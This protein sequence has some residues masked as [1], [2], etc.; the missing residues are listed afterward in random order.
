MYN[1]E[2]Y[3]NF[4]ELSELLNHAA[5]EYSDFCDLESLG[6]SREGRDVWL[7]TLTNKSSGLHSDKPA[8]W[9]SGNIHARELSGCQAALHTIFKILQGV[10]D[11]DP[12]YVHLLSHNTFY[13]VPRISPDGADAALKGASI[14][15]V[16]HVYPDADSPGF[17]PQDMDGDGV[18]RWILKPDEGGVWKKSE[19]DSRILVQRQPN[20][21]NDNITYYN[22]LPEGRFFG[23]KQNLMCV[24]NPW[25]L[26]YNRNFPHHWQ[27]E[28]SQM[29]AGEIPLS[30][31]ETRAVAE[32]I[33]SR[34]N[35]IGAQDFHTFS[36]VILRPGINIADEDMPVNDL[37]AYKA[38]A[39]IGEDI[40]GYPCVS[41]HEGFKIHKK[42]LLCGGFIDWLYSQRGA[43]TFST[44]IWNAFK[45]SGIE[46]KDN[47]HLNFFISYI[48]AE[49]QSK[50][51]EWCDKNASPGYFKNWEKMNHMDL[52][53]IEIGGMD[54]L[55]TIWNPP[56]KLLAKEVEK[57]AEFVI[58]MAECNPRIKFTAA[59]II[60][61]EGDLK[62]IRVELQNIGYLPSSGA[63][64]VS[65]K[66]KEEPYATIRPGKGVQLVTGENYVPIQPLA[67]RSRLGPFRS[68][69]LSYVHEQP[70][71]RLVSEWVV[72]GSGRVELEF[73]FFKGGKLKKA[74]EI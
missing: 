57:N 64:S 66:G 41:I 44:E 32:A 46:I 31:P 37:E 36:A 35:I 33:V 25:G 53:E 18:V 6:K 38:F 48:S 60:P 15:S 67:G 23:E 47:E 59:E 11:K 54:I 4:Q 49:D 34:K 45:Q 71:N 8:Y 68:Q 9:V 26:D 61:L 19:Q 74:L 52:G 2:K 42:A 22:L 30:N 14:R 7:V 70:N 65:E 27:P 3:L 13:I 20:E 5:L 43:F 73:N 29:G 51:L 69:L 1:S 72:C 24:R 16:Q 17:H 58:A 63:E 21:Y 40:T 55:R 62:H 56:E 12:R 39:K 10:R 28:S 50:L